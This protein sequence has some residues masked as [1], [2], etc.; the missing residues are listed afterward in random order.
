M[1]ER[2]FEN[3]SAEEQQHGELNEQSGEEEND[4]NQSEEEVQSIK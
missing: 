1:P 4:E 2:P 3:D